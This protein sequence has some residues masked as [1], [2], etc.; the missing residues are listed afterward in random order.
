MPIWVGVTVSAAF[1][2]LLLVCRATASAP[3]DRRINSAEFKAGNKAWSIRNWLPVVLFLFFLACYIALII[4]WE[5]FAYYGNN[6]LTC[7]ALRGSN[8]SPLIWVGA[9]RFTPLAFLEFNFIRHLGTSVGTYY[10]LPILQLL[11]V[12]AIL[13]S[14]DADLKFTARLFLTACLLIATGIVVSFGSLI[15]PE[16]NEVFWLVCLI[17]AVK[18]FD[19]TH[20]AGMAI[21]AIVSAQFMLYYKETAFLILW[22][23]VAG[24]SLLCCRNADR[25]G[26][27]FSRLWEKPS[28]LDFCL[29]SLG[30]IFLLYYGAVMF[31]HTN[32][33]YLQAARWP[34]LEVLLSYIKTDLLAFLLTITALARAF[35]IYQR[36]IAPSP[37]WE[38]LAYGGVTYFIAF[39]WLRI[40]SVYY[41]APTD[42]IAVLYLGR[43][44][45]LSWR[46][47]Q[48]GTKA[49]LACGIC[50]VL[51]QNAL[52]ST[53]FE[54]YKKN[55]IHAK[56]EIATVVQ[57]QFQGR[58]SNA[59]RLFFPFAGRYEMME[60]GAY[61]GYRGLPIERAEDK[62]GLAETV[63]LVTPALTKDEPLEV[64]RSI[65]G[66]AGGDPRSGDLVVVLPEDDASLAQTRSF[67]E[68]G[69][70]IF[71]YS[72][73]P[74]LPAWLTS[75][76]RKLYVPSPSIGEPKIL[77]D[78]WLR[79]SVT[80]WE[81]AQ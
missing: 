16:R 54:Y 22:G 17:F 46:D 52:L 2:T 53:T 76:G 27:D 26:W 12:C 29:A 48:S 38:G 15:Y 41:L 42:V 25:S 6:Q 80:V 79:A 56:S 18:R 9:G 33:E 58:A 77:P 72:P 19:Q 69:S 40:Y 21:A 74:H 51:T 81:G 73:S 36:R 62:P 47:L 5:D 20:S 34:E 28:R 30:L 37:F 66:R 14:F 71:L 1:V 59:K 43:L 7:V 60:F 49:A 45:F 23:F 3:P 75:L 61:L 39:C 35:R 32:L 57:E 78:H 70:T 10:A 13:L 67:L 63:L 64:Y 68:G 55:L 44:V 31:R 24:R 50:L 4:K 65:M 11:I 8:Y